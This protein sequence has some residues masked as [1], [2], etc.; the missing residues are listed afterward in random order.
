MN[1]SVDNFHLSPDGKKLWVG[2]HAVFWKVYQ[3]LNDPDVPAPSQVSH[4]AK[5]YISNS[6]IKP[7]C[8]VSYVIFS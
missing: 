1:T 5:M 8:F 7:I 4:W 2:S 6:C 3:Q